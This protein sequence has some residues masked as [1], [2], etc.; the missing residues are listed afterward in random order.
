MMTPD[1][2]EFKFCF[3]FPIQGILKNLCRVHVSDDPSSSWRTELT[4]Y[5]VKM[6]QDMHEAA[7]LTLANLDPWCI[8]DLV[9]KLYFGHLCILSSRIGT[10]GEQLRLWM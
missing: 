4:G 7:A 5:K 10:T 6:V 1:A 8:A 3:Q 2:N 9:L